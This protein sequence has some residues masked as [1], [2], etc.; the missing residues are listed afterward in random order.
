MEVHDDPI[1]HERPVG[2][3][4]TL[5]FHGSLDPAL[6]L[7]GLEPCAEQARRRTLEESFEEPL[8]GGQ[9]RHGR[10]QT[11][12]GSGTGREAAHALRMAQSGTGPSAPGAGYRRPRVA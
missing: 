6:E 5:R 8:D 1:G 11:S 4:E 3:G 2:C 12:R 10:S 9:R 7:D